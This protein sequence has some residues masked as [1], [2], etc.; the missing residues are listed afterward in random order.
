MKWCSSTTEL[1]C[2]G[3]HSRCC[4]GNQTATFRDSSRGSYVP[5]YVIIWSIRQI[6][7]VYLIIVL[8]ERNIHDGT[9]TKQNCNCLI[10]LG[11]YVVQ[12]LFGLGTGLVNDFHRNNWLKLYLLNCWDRWIG[13]FSFL[14]NSW[15]NVVLHW[16]FYCENII[17]IFFR[18]IIYKKKNASAILS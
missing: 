8:T 16:I 13:T 11:S 7:N 6:Q 3:L 14:L 2:L 1:R 15:R 17:Q 10:H 5:S 18:T 9:L 4:Y 12:S